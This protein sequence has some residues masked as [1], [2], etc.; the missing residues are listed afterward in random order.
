MNISFA[1]DDVAR[2]DWMVTVINWAQSVAVDE[3]GYS[4]PQWVI[5][6]GLELPYRLLSPLL[7]GPKRIEISGSIA[8][9]AAAQRSQL[10]LRYAAA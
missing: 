8:M 6:H 1:E 7:P 5:G 2:R 10:V 4:P 9:L 3:S